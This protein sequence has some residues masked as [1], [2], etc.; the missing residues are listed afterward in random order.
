MNV[1]TNDNINFNVA[2]D[3]HCFN[4]LRV[5]GTLTLKP[6]TYVINGGDVEFGS[7]SKISCTGC[8]IMLTNTN[9]SL[10][11]PIGK[12]S[13]TAGSEV[14]MSAPTSGTYNGLLF[15]QDRRA[16]TAN[17]AVNTIN[18]NS[19]SSFSGAM[20]FPKQHLQVNGNAGLEFNCAQF[21]AWTV[22]FSGNSGI[23]N[24]CTGG[25]PPPIMGLHVRLVA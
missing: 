24:T 21:V 18:G 19:D 2:G 6:G 15:Y 1:G 13:M 3:V 25:G 23:T 8:T 9:N 7:Q 10:T 17:N 22:E 14:N 11:A 20:Y 4:N 16:T 5:Q 12:L